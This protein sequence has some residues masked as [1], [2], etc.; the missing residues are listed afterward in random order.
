MG[1]IFTEMGRQPW[2]VQGLLKTADGVSTTVSAGTVAVSMIAYTLLYGALAGV[3]VWIAVREIR[4]DT[5][6]GPATAPDELGPDLS[7]AY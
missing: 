5:Q 1:W 7:V 2:V 4:K 3:A 6:A